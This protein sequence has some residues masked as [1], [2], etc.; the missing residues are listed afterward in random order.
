M[1]TL[2]KRQAFVAASASGL[3]CRTDTLLLQAHPLSSDQDASLRWIGY[4]A[5]RKLGNATV[6]N[7]AKRR[8]R[9]AARQWLLPDAR[10]DRYYILIARE[11]IRE[12]SYDKLC[13]DLRYGLKKLN[14]ME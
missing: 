1:A 8:M 13:G 11:A 6:R 10:A 7:R 12:C 4:T 14:G 3:K 9:E 2:N 5:T